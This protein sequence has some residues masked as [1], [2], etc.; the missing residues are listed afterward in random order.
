MVELSSRSNFQ[1]NVDVAGI[2]EAPVHL[3][4]VRVVEEHLDLD[5][6]GELISDFLLLQQTLLDHLQRTHE[7]CISLANQV[8]PTVLT[9][10]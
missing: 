8:H 1:Y 4:D 7:V 6:A 5:F 9:V 3:D 2:V 10:S